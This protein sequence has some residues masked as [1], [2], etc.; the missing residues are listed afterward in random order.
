MNNKIIVILISC[1]CSF[2]ITL[3]AQKAV[4]GLVIDENSEPLIGASVLV[5]GTNV[6]ITTNVN[7]EFS[8]QVNTANPVLVVSYLGYKR[9]EVR[10][11]A[12]F[13]RIIMQ[14]D[15]DN[16]LNEVMVVGY[17]TQRKGSVTGSV[18]QV[19][20]REINQSPV[21]A[22]SNMI[23]GKL[24]GLVSKQSSGEPGSDGASLNIRGSSTFGSSNA[25][26]IIV[27]GIRR[28]FD[29]LDPEEIES[30]TI[31]KDASAAAVYGLQAAAGVILV[32]TKKGQE[33]KPK[34]RLQ[35]STSMS[36]NTMFP[37]FLNGPEYAYWYDKARELNG[38]TPL[39]SNES[40]SKMINGDP[41][42][43]WGNTNWVEELFQTGIT[44]HT[45][46]SVDG[47]NDRIKYFFNVGYY[48]QKGNVKNIDFNRYNF[49]TNIEAKISKDFRVAVGI[50][51]RKETRQAPTFSTEKNTWNNVFQ[52][53]MRTH[54]YLPKTYEGYP[55]GNITN[56]PLV[57]P[58]A[59]LENSGYRHNYANYFES[60]L[61]AHWDLPWITE[62][63]SVNF[64]GSF[65]NRY[66]FAKA[67][68]QPFKLA[69]GT[70]TE[71]GISYKIVESSIGEYAKLAE[72]FSQR[73]F[74]TLNTSL[75]Y[76]RKFGQHAVSG[77]LL[78]EQ[79][80][81]ISNSHSLSTRG[82]DFYDLDE[83]DFAKELMP[84]TGAFGG[85]SSIVPNAG[86]V[87][88]IN[89]GYADKY[90]LEVS[91]RYDGSYKF[92]GVNRWTLF[93]AVSVG[94]RISEENFF[95]NALPFFSNL[96]FR[97]SVGKLGNDTGVSAYMFL[98]T[99]DAVSNAPSVVIGDKA[100][101]AYQ[102]NAL[103]NPG[104]RWETVTVYNGGFEANL[105]NNLLG[106]EFDVFY[107]VTEDILERQGGTY[108]P[109]V[110]GYY[111]ATVNTGRADNRGFELIL[112]HNNRMGDFNYGAR[113]NLSW[114][115]NRYLSITDSP[116]M[117]DHLKRNGRAMGEKHGLVALGL[118]QTD[119]EAQNWPSIFGGNKAGDIKYLDV[120]GDG[121]LTY[122]DDRM[123]IAGSN[124][125]KLFSSLSLNADYK[126][127]DFSIMFQG[128]ALASYALSGYYPDLGYDNT[129]FTTAFFQYGNTPKYLVENMWTPDNKD[130]KY[131]RLSDT[132]VQ[133]NKWAST[134]WL[135]DGSYLRLKTVQL[136][137]SI[138][139]KLVRGL[140]LDRFRVFVSGGNLF[141]LTEFPYMDPEAPDVSNGF[142]PQQRVYSFGL[143]LTF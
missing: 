111:P 74:L 45:N 83:L 137:Y 116:N 39:F 81:T 60:N 133:N 135:V 84:G 97:G 8:L 107:K 88:R 4:S 127:I 23:V 29:Q 58:I 95:K 113:F 85:T 119:E 86:Y 41:D 106:V 143:E 62:G 7:G 48:D 49:R 54:P 66:T 44:Q 3:Y 10:V 43:L 112:T 138:P 115:K 105:W 2:F 98:S 27:D 80:R 140:G 63:L 99:M 18:A 57:S 12:D 16:M 118:F 64:T 91:G 1:L 114:H 51:G 121:K 109:S 72:N 141:T 53:A 42:G 87:G 103:A 89:Y 33:G 21:G 75:N 96:K 5:K 30:I 142:Y 123:W 93:P 69:Q 32:T 13:L 20:A 102:T 46:V 22:I 9:Q 126:G 59:A 68:Q 65:D 92:V 40:I 101:L 25:P 132:K 14:P 110:G 94:W 117:Q 77:L 47:G 124:V 134:L 56:G 26:V 100:E 36:Q 129:E 90:L 73:N 82:F 79:Y 130:A 139:K 70:V 67:F 108:A 55:T 61:S 136:G 37:E 76:H 131:P 28:S 6:G 31:L 120:N 52:Q 15:E 24:P 11:N 128:A 50:G 125:P 71:S 38:K 19:N 17:G 104:L 78:Y 35:S 34:I 122:N